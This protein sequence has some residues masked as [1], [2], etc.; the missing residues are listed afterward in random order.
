MHRVIHKI[1]EYIESNLYEEI[2]L[3]ELC[4]RTNY[5]KS[6][7]SRTINKYLGTSLS[8]YIMR[9]RLSLSA[10]MIKETDK[11]LS[12]I[13]DLFG[14]NSTKYYSTLFKKEFEIS[15]S[16]YRKSNKYIY[17]YPKRIVKGGQ[18]LK[19]TSIN[20]ILDYLLEK[21]SNEDELLDALSI[22]DN[23]EMY[24]QNDSEI[25]LFCIVEK[26]Y[27]GLVQ[28]AMNLISGKHS[29]RPVFTLHN[30]PNT[31]MTSVF[32]DDDEFKIEFKKGNKKIHANLFYFG[33]SYFEVSCETYVKEH[34]D[35]NKDEEFRQKHLDIQ[36][37][38][39]NLLKVHN[40]LELEEKINSDPNLIKFKSF[41]NEYALIY[42][43]TTKKHVALFSIYLNLKERTYKQI[44]VFT[45]PNVY[46]ELTFI[47]KQNAAYIYSNDKELVKATIY[48][49][50]LQPTYALKFPNG[51]TGTGSWDLTSIFE[52]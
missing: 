52:E 29:V 11:T 26:D 36:Q 34:G 6:H 45:T 46:D 28:L 30:S 32:R 39:E 41:I 16:D 7:L 14:F 40:N 27:N 31:S 38:S 4:L 19:L 8:S 50:D 24:K 15:P 3:D 47:K 35:F 44:N 21:S 51:S 42:M 49:R 23:V 48:S 18:T 2:T 12:Y 17:L 43:T 37:Y 33:D 13:S 5:S 25:E 1:I 22:L 9:R 20:E 10:V